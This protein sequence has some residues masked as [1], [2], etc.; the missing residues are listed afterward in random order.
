M[1]KRRF[2]EARL[3]AEQ[4]AGRRAVSAQQRSETI[5]QWYREGKLAKYYPN[6]DEGQYFYVIELP[7]HGGLRFEE[8][9]SAYPSEELFAY[10][11]LV[12]G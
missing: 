8:H 12:L 9:R 4:E 6:P 2:R 11:M 3:K 7:K 5:N 1:S 10:L